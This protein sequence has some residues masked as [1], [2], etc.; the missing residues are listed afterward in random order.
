[1][2]LAVGL[3]AFGAQRVAGGAL[4]FSS[5][6]QGPRVSALTDEYKELTAEIR[7]RIDLQQR[8][9]NVLV[10]LLTAIT[11]YLVAYAGDHGLDT[12]GV[13]DSEVLLLVALAPVLINLFIWR[14]VDHDVN[15]IDKAAYINR[16]L[17]PALTECTGGKPVLGFEEFLHHRRRARPRRVGPFLDFGKEDVPM[18]FLLVTFLA[19]G[20]LVRFTVHSRAGEARTIFD[21]TLYMG[22]ALLFVSL[23]MAILVGT[24]YRNVG[25]PDQETAVP[26]AVP[27]ASGIDGLI[28]QAAR[29]MS[30]VGR[31]L[32][33][34]SR[35]SS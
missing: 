3:Q 30:K 20:W 4:V 27:P 34:R 13:A 2:G 29:I 14:H 7:I 18:F 31:L 10:I 12:H 23:I 24:G 22:T 26:E 5:E 25:G 35:C 15:I 16:V 6:N 9:M 33:K 21:V 17:R 8:N 1:M 28:S 19:A 32:R 11:G